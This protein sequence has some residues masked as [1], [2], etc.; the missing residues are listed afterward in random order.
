LT[1][2]R[3]ELL[4]TTNYSQKFQHCSDFWLQQLKQRD[5]ESRRIMIVFIRVIMTHFHNLETR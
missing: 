3:G 5:I 4:A 2:F 1:L